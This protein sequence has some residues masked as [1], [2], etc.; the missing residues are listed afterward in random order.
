[1]PAE[2]RRSAANLTRKP[3]LIVRHLTG[4]LAGKEERI[5]SGSGR[6]M[7]GREAAP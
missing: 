4:P 7:F 5:D 6:V 1:M 2:R 3:L